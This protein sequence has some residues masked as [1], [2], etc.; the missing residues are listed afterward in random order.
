MKMSVMS[1]KELLPPK[2]AV[3]AQGLRELISAEYTWKFALP[4]KSE[5]A[6]LCSSS[7][8]NILQ[9]YAMEILISGYSWCQT[10][11]AHDE[12]IMVGWTADD[13]HLNTTCL[14]FGNLFLSFLNIEMRNLR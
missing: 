9:N 11:L 2:R 4:E 5:V 8:T 1:Q 3:P 12:E 10:C 6:S 13:S 14:F 7:N